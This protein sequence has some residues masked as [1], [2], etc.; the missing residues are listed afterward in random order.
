[1]KENLT[2]RINELLHEKNSLKHLSMEN[3]H[4]FEIFIRK[5]IYR[6]FNILS[7]DIVS[8]LASKSHYKDVIYNEDIHQMSDDQYYNLLEAKIDHLKLHDRVNLVILN[9]I[10]YL[11]DS[12]DKGKDSVYRNVKKKFNSGDLN[13]LKELLNF[14]QY[15]LFSYIYGTDRTKHLLPEEL[16]YFKDTTDS[17][18]NELKAIFHYKITK[19]FYAERP[20]SEYENNLNFRYSDNILYYY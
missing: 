19:V 17:I 8:V 13:N 11:A 2:T 6:D 16:Q 18:F 4:Y 5:N 1:M 15:E 7:D 9:V 20:Y 10:K 14:F 12:D 3:L